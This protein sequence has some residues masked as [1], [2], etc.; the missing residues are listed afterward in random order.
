MADFMAMAILLAAPCLL[1]AGYSI[2]YLRREI[3]TIMFFLSL[4]VLFSIGYLMDTPTQGAGVFFA[5]MVV[6][7][8]FTIITVFYYLGN[9][10]FQ[11]LGARLR[12]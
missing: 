3:A 12:K 6:S 7:L 11:Y 8:A 9:M 1:A 2:F 10:A 5:L 4:F